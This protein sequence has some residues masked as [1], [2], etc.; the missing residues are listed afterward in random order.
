MEKALV[1]LAPGFEEIEAVTIIDLL[2]RGKIDV[3]V[4]GLELDSVTGSH[5]IS[6]IPDAYYLDVDPDEFDVLILPGGQP[7]SNNL[8]ENRNIINWVNSRFK[9]GKKLAAICSAPV[10]FHAT[11]IAKGMKLTSYPTDKG[12]FTDSVYLEERVVRDGQ[13]ITSR[14]VGTAIDFSLAII[15]DL[16]GKEEAGEVAARILYKV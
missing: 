16:K 7:G 9:S 8:K 4:A 10:V 13:I 2:R 6:I 14:G 5:Q 11:G 12:I 3:T 1:I 15:S